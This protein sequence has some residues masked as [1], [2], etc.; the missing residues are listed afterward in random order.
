MRRFGP[1]DRLSRT[2][3]L[4]STELD[5]ETILM[6]ID[7]GAYYG[8]E[9]AARRIWEKLENPTSFSELVDWLVREYRVSRETCA[10]DLQKFLGEIE[11]EG[12]LRVE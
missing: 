3:D 9:G 7:A 11:R 12:L 1:E 5:Q 6:S 10:S 8:L 2:K 4:L